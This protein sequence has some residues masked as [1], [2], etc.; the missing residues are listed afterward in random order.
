MKLQDNT[1]GDSDVISSYQL[2]SAILWGKLCEMFVIL[3][4]VL[5]VT[6]SIR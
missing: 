5:D 6:F 2:F 4:S 3:T 1:Q